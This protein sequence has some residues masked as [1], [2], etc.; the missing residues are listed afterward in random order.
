MRRTCAERAAV[1]DGGAGG[2]DDDDEGEGETGEKPGGNG[3]IARH[4]EGTDSMRLGFRGVASRLSNLA[5]RLAHVY[6]LGNIFQRL[7]NEN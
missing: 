6:R 5:E 3:V 1:D 4:F 2:V 7:R